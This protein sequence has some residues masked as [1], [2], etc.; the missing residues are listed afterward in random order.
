MLMQPASH[1][2]RPDAFEAIP[3]F[4]SSAYAYLGG[5]IV[6][7]GRKKYDGHSASGVT[8][9]PRNA[10]RAWQP[11]VTTFEADRLGHGARMARRLFEGGA[12]AAIRPAGLMLWLVGEALPFPLTHA[13][14]R[15]DA[16]R[17]AL[18]RQDIRAFEAAALR[19]LGLGHGL[20]PSGDDF[21]GGILFALHCAPVPVWRKD[22]PV[23][24]SRLH[25]AAK[26]AT[27]VISAALLD[28]LMDGASYRALH[29]TMAALHS[30]DAV[31]IEA[32]CTHLM[33]LGASSGS[34][35]LAGVLLALAPA[36]RF[37]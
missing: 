25:A 36:P 23:L 1:A 28:D 10:L 30:E 31:K 20:T 6:W 33:G 8:D 29:E 35:I 34:D 14:A 12:S 2:T 7:T 18:A 19:V 24:K 5:R 13:S 21:V 11:E 26:V 16:I 37:S 15:F 32:A 3:G 9:H 22:L 27:N 17:D 4:E